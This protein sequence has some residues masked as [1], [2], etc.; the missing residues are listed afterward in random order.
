[1]IDFGRYSKHSRWVVAVLVALVSGFWGIARQKAHSQ[2]LPADTRDYDRPMSEGD[3]PHVVA[4]PDVDGQP[5]RFVV[6]DGGGW[7]VFEVAPRSAGRTTAGGSSYVV[8][9]LDK[10]EPEPSA[11]D[12]RNRARREPDPQTDDNRTPRDTDPADEQDTTK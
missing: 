2:P 8:R 5:Q 10:L 4:L 7:D 1:M 3:A 6:S 11:D 12:R 9:R